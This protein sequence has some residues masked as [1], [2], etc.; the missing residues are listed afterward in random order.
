LDA[1][2]R[3]ASTICAE[4]YGWQPNVVGKILV[5]PE[6]RGVRRDVERHAGVLSLALPS[7]TVAVKRWLGNP[8]GPM[9]GVMFL[10]TSQLVGVTRN[11][12]AIRRVRSVKTRANTA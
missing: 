4:R 5:L 12:S 3:L 7:R 10:A 9:S 2:T 11:P 8:D 6:D 1:K